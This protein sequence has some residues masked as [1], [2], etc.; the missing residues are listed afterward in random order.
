MTEN[1]IGDVVVASAIEVHRELGPGMLESV[2]QQALAFEIRQWAVMNPELNR[3]TIGALRSP[4][5][6]CAS[7]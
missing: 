4:R 1:Q 2:Y 6:P 5:C 3:P 7:A